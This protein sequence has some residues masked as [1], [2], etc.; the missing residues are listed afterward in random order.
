[1]CSCHLRWQLG[2]AGIVF[3]TIV[4]RWVPVY[5]AGPAY[6][7]TT[8]PVSLSLSVHPGTN[9]TKTL[10]LMNNSSQPVNIKMKLNV[11]SPSGANG[12][13]TIQEPKRDDSSVDWVHF[14]PSTF[15]ARPGVW[16]DV[17][18]TISLPASAA[19]GYYYAVLFEPQLPDIS[20][21]NATFKG[22]NAILV[23]VDTQSGDERRAVSLNNFAASQS[24][25][26]YLPAEFTVDVRNDGNIYLAPFGNIYI[27][28]KA[29]VSDSIAAIDINPNGGNILP[30]SSR[31]YQVEWSDGFPLFADK[32]I[33]GQIVQD[34]NGNPVKEL[35]WNFTKL[36]KLRFGRYYARVTLIYND[37]K[38][39]VPIE[40]ITSF[41]VI[42][43]KLILILLVIVLV[44]AVGISTIGR[45]AV[46]M[47][48]RTRVYRR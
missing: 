19:L 40:R 32:K 46:R 8:S 22:T 23:L 11:F 7:L 18:M 6:S 21:K 2:F 26:E 20:S 5:A 31:D 34:K 24:L 44:L 28:R 15:T 39:V 14:S 12:E 16:S 4:L 3:A 27:S 37:G 1:M 35:V 29:D 33:S 45:F 42:P 36:N 10:Q 41:W 9:M 47:I 38:R 17:K 13:A 30:H 25:Y 48:R 43:W